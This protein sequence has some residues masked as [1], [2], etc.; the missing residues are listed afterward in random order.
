MAE[1]DTSA[2]EEKR[3]LMK[4]EIQWRIASILTCGQL[5][6]AV[7]EVVGRFPSL[8]EIASDV[9]KREQSSI[10][11]YSNEIRDIKNG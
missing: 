11:R 5:I 9:V 7:N 10:N 2:D 8:S 4:D 3:I 6:A 1:Q